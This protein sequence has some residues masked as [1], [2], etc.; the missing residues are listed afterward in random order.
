ME[1]PE[2]LTCSVACRVRKK[3]GQ[4]RKLW[5]KLGLHDQRAWE[6][7]L[8]LW[9][10]SQWYKYTGAQRGAA[11][12]AHWPNSAE[13]G[14]E[15]WT[16]N[17][18]NAITE[19]ALRAGVP[20]P[21]AAATATPA[22]AAHSDSIQPATANPSDRSAS[23]PASSE[24]QSD[25]APASPVAQSDSL[26]APTDGQSDSIPAAPVTQSDPAPGVSAF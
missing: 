3:A 11:L 25:P 12:F 23:V 19:L 24:A 1:P 14:S 9:E 6:D 17:V 7:V 8:P 13:W 26:R 4:G 18:P 2:S 5:E 20:I 15:V 21:T 10:Q 16:A 22:A